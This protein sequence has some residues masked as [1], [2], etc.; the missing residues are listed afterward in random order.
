VR[1]RDDGVNVT[2]ALNEKVAVVTGAAQ[3]IGRATALSF[4][5]EGAVTWA[6]DWNETKLREL[7]DAA[8]IRTLAMDVTNADAIASAAARI[9]A[10]DILVNGVGW[11]HVGNILECEP[12][13]WSRTFDLNVRSMYLMIRSFL[14][15]MLER[16]GGSII[17]IA[18]VVSSVSGAPK[19]CAY[20][21]SK[22]AVI[23][24]TKAVAAD[25]MAR[26]IRCNAICPGPSTLR[27]LRSGLERMRIP[28][29]P[30]R[31]SSPASRSV[32]WA[33][34]TRSRSCVFTSPPTP[35]PSWSGL[36]S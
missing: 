18:S 36:L 7:D 17:N 29:R 26:G 34:R 33:G 6:I 25:F 9:G 12:S 24:L 14:P 28:P 21:A 2:A 22:G 32:G 4:G 13:D 27:R 3:G 1:Q 35:P 23:G 10:V 20:A 19:R 16:G 5:R 11:A 30:R 8:G 31:L 15:L